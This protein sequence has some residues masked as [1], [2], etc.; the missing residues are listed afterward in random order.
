MEKV[1]I[2]L[3]WLMALVFFERLAERKKVS[4]PEKVVKKDKTVKKEDIFPKHHLKETGQTEPLEQERKTIIPKISPKEKFLEKGFK[5]HDAQKAVVYS[6]IIL[7]PR[8]KRPFLFKIVIL[9]LVLAN[10]GIPNLCASTKKKEELK[11]GTVIKKIKAPGIIPEGIAFDGKHL[12]VVALDLDADLV[13]TIYQMNPQDGKILSFF[14]APGKFPEG[15][16]FDGHYLWNIDLNI[17]SNIVG[18]LIYKINL[19]L[20]NA[21]V[22]FPAPE[23]HPG[24]IPTGIAWSGKY[25]WCA[26]VNTH[27]IFKIDSLSGKIIY[28]FKAPAKYPSGIVFSKKFLWISS[29]LTQRIYKI[30]PKNGRVIYSFRHPGTYPY[31]LAFEDKYLWSGDYLNNTLYKMIP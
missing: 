21:T 24:S 5:L 23:L 30:N 14:P 31:G 22:A 27:S 3:L 25:L 29:I 9:V 13:P 19:D 10:F 26:D 28:K 20:K 2:L 1:L 16:S 18:P 4:S 12:W 17:E 7:P 8:A 11:H 15:L 6:E